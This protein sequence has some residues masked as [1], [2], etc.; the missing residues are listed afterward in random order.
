[1]A[2]EFGA[3]DATLSA[4]AGD[5]REL[6]HELRMGFVE[7]LSRQVDLLRRSRCD[8]NWQVTAKRILGLAE[9]FHLSELALLAEQALAAAPGE[10]VVVRRLQ[11]FLDE[12]RQV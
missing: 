12:V 11:L 7:S 8:A 10:P 1:M 6:F 3:L 2:F 4:A 5:D 9:S